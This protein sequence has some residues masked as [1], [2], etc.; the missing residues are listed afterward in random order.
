MQEE[1]EKAKEDRADQQ[2]LRLVDINLLYK[3]TKFQFA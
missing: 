2:G 3:P 1:F